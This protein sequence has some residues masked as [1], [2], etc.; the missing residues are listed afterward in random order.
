MS[1]GGGGFSFGASS[2]N[3]TSNN[4]NGAAPANK[5]FSFGGESCTCDH[6]STHP[7]S[8]ADLPTGLLISSDNNDR[9]VQL[10][11]LIVWLDP[12]SK[13]S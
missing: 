11:R 7:S 13:W 8:L 4:S 3:N 10:W 6:N 9:L 2:N 12:S 5:P 1:F